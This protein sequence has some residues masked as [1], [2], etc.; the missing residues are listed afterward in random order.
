MQEIK[1]AIIMRSFYQKRHSIG[2]GMITKYLFDRIERLCNFPRIYTDMPNLKD[3]DVALIFGIPYHNSPNIPGGIL[4]SDVK[5]INFYGDLPCYG[6]KLCEKNKRLMF[7]RS[8]VIIGGFYERFLEW[9]PEFVHKYVFFPGFYF[10]Y[11]R[12]EKLKINANPIMKCLLS[13]ANTKFYPFRQYIKTYCTRNARETDKL[14][15]I[16]RRKTV[17]HEIYHKFLNTYFCA[18]ATS[19]MHNCIVG[20]YFEIPAA[21]VLLL[22]E[23]EKELDMLGFEPDVHYVPIVRKNI[24]DQIRKVLK[25]PEDYTEMRVKARAFVREYHSDINRAQQFK[26]IVERLMEC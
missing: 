4:E 22:A 18:I 23:R 24:F 8:D 20:K 21:G 16:K 3:L 13:G 14:I 7:E 9:Y 11:E 2:M 12:Y 15:S 6:D 5:I 19:G 10:P 26:T 1:G 25:C 17:R